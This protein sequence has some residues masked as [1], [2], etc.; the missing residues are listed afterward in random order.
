MLAKFMQMRGKFSNKM[1][2]KAAFCQEHFTDTFQFKSKE[3][4]PVSKKEVVRAKTI[5]GPEKNL[6][7]ILMQNM[8]DEADR[9]K[10]LQLADFLDK[11]LAM[12]P[13]YRMTP[14]AALR[15]PFLTE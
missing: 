2:K 10:I 3:L 4:D 14:D 5:T 13:A 11:A 8:E 15:H 9:H 6:K 1:L 7:Q 12:D